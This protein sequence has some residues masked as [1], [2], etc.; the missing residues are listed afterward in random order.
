MRQVG[1]NAL[2]EGEFSNSI[3]EFGNQ[4]GGGNEIVVQDVSMAA[5][6]FGEHQQV[7]E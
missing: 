7:D 2:C 3:E 1:R 4:N 6:I 5:E